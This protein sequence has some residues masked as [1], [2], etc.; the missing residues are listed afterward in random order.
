MSFS[1]NRFSRKALLLVTAVFSASLLWAQTT[2]I[3]GR[4]LDET[5]APVIGATVMVKGTTIATATNV[6]GTFNLKNTDR[7]VTLVVSY[8]GYEAQQ[9]SSKGAGSVTITLKPEAIG[10][11]SVEIVSVGYGTQKRE[12][13]VGAI[14]TIRPEE[15]RVPV[16]SLS[17]TLAGNLAGVVALQTSGEPG[18]DDAQFWIRGIATFTGSPDPLILVDGIE[19]PLNDV[20]PL[21][22]ESFSVLKDASAT[23]VYGVRGANGV[24]LVNTR[25]GF[26]GPAR[27]DLRYEQGFSFASKR[28]SFVDAATRSEMFN[29]AVDA[30]NASAALKYGADEIKAMRMQTDPEVYPDVD[31]QKLLMKKVSLSEKVSAN[32]SGGGKFARYFTALSFYNQEGQYAVKPGEYSWVSD[33][34]G[35]YGENVN[36]K[37]YNFRSNV[38]MDITKTT[39]VN[40]GVQGNVT[41]NME[42]VEGSAAIYRDIINAAPNAFPVR[43]KDGELAGR[44]GL[45]NPYNMLT[46]RGWKKTTGNTLRANLTINQDFSFITPGLSAKVS[47][48][49]DAV[50]YSVEERAR[51][52][53]FFEADDVHF[54]DLPGYGFA[55]RSKAERDRWAELIGDFF[56][57]ERSFNLVVSLVDI[58]HDPS[59]LDHDMIDYLQGNE[60]NFIVSP[61]PTSS[62]APSR[63]ARQQPSKSSSTFRPRT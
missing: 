23:A 50:N 18:K 42:P 55:R 60:F 4:V 41:E 34:I 17:Q 59:K 57:S 45:N 35:R 33:K 13:V 30:V 58:R 63:P 62:V 1:T 28:L 26:D 39:V 36:Y 19:R 44:D 7:N 52:I 12:S 22:I 37:R 48:A 53:N 40:L 51:N 47:Y 24:I 5:G 46:Q 14:S 32:I 29:E 10:M 6:D 38:D 43:F 3:S 49:Y 15:L 61:R 54:V 27:I 31:W 2:G 9:V 56:D 11:E 8:V 16:R 21:E 20:D 25:R